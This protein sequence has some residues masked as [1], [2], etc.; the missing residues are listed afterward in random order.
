M[1]MIMPRG[2]EEERWTPAFAGVTEWDAGVT[3]RGAGREG[4]DARGRR[5]VGRGGDVAGSV[6]HVPDRF[7]C[8]VPLF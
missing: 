7:A 3:V 1:G 6:V 2:G 8:D 4:D 5:R